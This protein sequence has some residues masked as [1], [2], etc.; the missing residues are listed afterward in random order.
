MSQ[1]NHE[2]S[3][4]NKADLSYFVPN[5][6]YFYLVVTSLIISRWSVE[7]KTL[8]DSFNQLPGYILLIQNL[9]Y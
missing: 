2:Q 7:I 4:I 9:K 6:D 8:D 1:D 3:S 5:I